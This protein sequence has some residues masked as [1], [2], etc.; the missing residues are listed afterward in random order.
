[1]L[2]VAIVP[3]VDQFSYA[4]VGLAHEH[5]LLLKKGTYR[6][7]IWVFDSVKLFVSVP[8]PNSELSTIILD[9]NSLA[10]QWIFTVLGIVI[11][12]FE[13]VANLGGTSAEKHEPIALSNELHR[14]DAAPKRLET[15]RHSALYHVPHDQLTLLVG[16]CEVHPVGFDGE[17]LRMLLVADLPNAPTLTPQT[18][19]A[20][21]TPT[22]DQ[23]RVWRVGE[24]LDDVSMCVLNGPSHAELWE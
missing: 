5:P 1:M 21:A 15:C 23:L 10:L 8:I 17:S 14:D 2:E 18:D 6:P 22:D 20:I 24:P 9:W 13:V 4:V 3:H 19:E 11:L 16:E 7:R 12:E